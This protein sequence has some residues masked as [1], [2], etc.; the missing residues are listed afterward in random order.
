VD[1]LLI[2][3]I[4]FLGNKGSSQEEF[5]HTFNQLHVSKKQIVICSDRPPK[6]IQNI[7]DRL[8]SRFEW[9]LV[10]DIQMPDLETRIAI[11]QKKAQIRNY[12]VPEDVISFLAQNVPSN[13]RELEGALNRII[14]CAELNSEPITEENATQW[15]KDI[16][17]HN[18]KGPVSVDTIQQIVAENFSLTVE[19]LVGNRRTSD[20]ALARQ[21]AMYLCRKL[22][23]I[24]LQQIGFSFRKK[25][26]TTVL[27]AQ[28]K[29]SK[30]VEE[31]P[32]MKEI[33]DNI[34]AKL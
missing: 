23:D 4:Q 5:F 16:I 10:T 11:L 31:Q 30:L 24:S 12:E 33:V 28:R 32:R 17:R 8:V 1:I 26:H 20:I 6:E 2:D 29:I 25:D 14:A 21:V 9:G 22:T 15:L 18:S 19:D 13:I 7:E 34:E 27:H 3:D